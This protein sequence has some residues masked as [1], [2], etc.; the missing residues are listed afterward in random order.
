[1]MKHTY[2]EAIHSCFR[3]QRGDTALY[4]GVK[5]DHKLLVALLLEHK[6]D[7]DIKCK[8]SQGRERGGLGAR[9]ILRR[10]CE[11]L[12]VGVETPYFWF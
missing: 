1:M 3:M 11:S 6:A 10:W 7:V 5:K 8:V 4:L 12:G 2:R 9:K